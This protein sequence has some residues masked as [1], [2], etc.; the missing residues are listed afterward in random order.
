MVVFGFIDV[1]HRSRTHGWFN[2]SGPSGCRNFALQPSRVVSDDDCVRV[3]HDGIGVMG[4]VP[5]SYK[6][7]VVFGF[8]DLDVSYRS[9]TP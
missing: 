1:S 4:G 3:P 6:I 7:R 9:R 2:F 5:K 8:L